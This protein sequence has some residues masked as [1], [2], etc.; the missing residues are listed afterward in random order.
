MLE[1]QNIH[2]LSAHRL[3]SPPPS[4]LYSIYIFT[5]NTFRYSNFYN[6]ILKHKI[7]HKTN[8]VNLKKKRSGALPHTVSVKL[9][10]G[11]VNHSKSIKLIG[12]C[13]LPHH[14][15]GRVGPI[16]TVHTVRPQ[17]TSLQ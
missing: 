10:L 4:I 6:H 1:F 14:E 11:L 16:Q 5:A 2:I 7:A 13:T 17:H 15:L 3:E 8:W 12:Q 9:Q